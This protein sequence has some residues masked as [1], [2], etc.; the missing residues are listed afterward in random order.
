MP[1]WSHENGNSLKYYRGYKRGH[2]RVVF[3]LR[4]NT[5]LA[6]RFLSKEY[7]KIA[8]YLHPRVSVML[9]IVQMAV[10][11]MVNGCGCF[12]VGNKKI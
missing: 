5:S 9:V 2:L 8:F 1:I 6:D 11:H 3:Y 12:K 10:G 4:V 7:S